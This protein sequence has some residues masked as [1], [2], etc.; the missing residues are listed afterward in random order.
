MCIGIPMCVLSA[1]DGRAVVEGRGERRTIETRLIDAVY[2]GD[3]LLVYL[4]SARER[5]SQ[6]RADEVNQMLDMLV[7]AMSGCAAR[8]MGGS[9]APDMADVGFALPSAMT[10]E[11]IAA[12]AGLPAAMETLT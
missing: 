11:Q 3:W 7:D 9:A 5:I 4:D 1:C 12:L 8:A 10:P 6:Q 2:A